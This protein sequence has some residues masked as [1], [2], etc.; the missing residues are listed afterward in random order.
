VGRGRDAARMSMH[1]TA[2]TGRPLL[3]LVLR[4]DALT[5]LLCGLAYLALAGPLADALG[6]PAG[7][8]RVLG[9]A[10]LAAA[11]V[12]ALAARRPSRGMVGEVALLNAAWAAGSLVVLLAGTWSPTT[13]GSVWIA[14]QAA[15]VAAFAAAQWRL[16]P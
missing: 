9:A 13:A 16:R 5:C 14:L 15:T 8:L 1:S 3:P 4:L 6:I 10:L 2:L 11:A 12:I 7:T